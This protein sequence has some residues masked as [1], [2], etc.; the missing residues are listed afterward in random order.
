M[1]N[2][3]PRVDYMQ[4]FRSILDDLI[5]AEI[6]EEEFNRKADEAIK[7]T[8]HAREYLIK[9]GFDPDEI[10]KQG[11]TFVKLLMRKTVLEK[12]DKEIREIIGADE[13]EATTDEVRSLM[14]NYKRAKEQMAKVKE[15]IDGVAD[16]F[17]ALVNIVIPEESGVSP[18]EVRFDYNESNAAKDEE[19][20]LIAGLIKKLPKDGIKII[21][22]GDDK[23]AQ[24]HSN[25]HGKYF[26]VSVDINPNVSI[27]NRTVRHD[28]EF[29]R[30]D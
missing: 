5:R 10:G 13:N 9:E 26:D 24:V 18:V 15:L 17:T 4:K 3:N 7:D 19:A 11:A 14:L 8:E 25:I 23:T 28:E 16:E 27:E 6:E 21:V 29:Y 2:E 30:I 22:V 1:H 12:E 20:N